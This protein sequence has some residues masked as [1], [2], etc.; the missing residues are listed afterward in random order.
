MKKLF[1]LAAIAAAL[2]PAHAVVVTQWNFNSVAP[3]AAPGTGTIVPS[4][5]NGTAAL[6]GGATG[7]FASG[8]A[9]GGSSDPASGDDSGWNTTTYAAQGTGD[10]SRGVSFKVDTTGYTNVMVS[11]DQRLSNTASRYTQ[12]QYTTDGTSFIDAAGGLFTGTPG[13]TWYNG[14]SLDLSNVTGV[15]NNANFGFRIVATF[16]PATSTY[17]AATAGSNYGTAGTNRFDMVTISAAPVPE[18]E[19]Y[20]LMLAGLAAVGLMARRRQA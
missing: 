15:A 14:R 13:D 11:W 2:S 10:K 18:P 20:A 8:D 3:D 5:G 6:V 7:T 16:A 1:A 17:V 9:T 19:T 12:V 4:I